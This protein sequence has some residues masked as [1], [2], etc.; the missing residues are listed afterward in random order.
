MK[1]NTTKLF[2]VLTTVCVLLT[3]FGA[4][5]ENQGWDCK[6][7]LESIAA[8]DEHLKALLQGIEE[9][10]RSER[11]FTKKSA[12]DQFNRGMEKERTSNGPESMLDPKLQTK[13]WSE[14]PDESQ[15]TAKV[16]VTCG[17]KLTLLGA[18]ADKLP[19]YQKMYSESDGTEPIEFLTENFGGSL[20]IMI[21]SAEQE[22]NRSERSEID[23][24]TLQ[25]GGMWLFSLGWPFCCAYQN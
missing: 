11:Q 20:Y 6:S 14:L 25:R 5:A 3:P 2:T 21:A 12:T 4:S 22:R 10:E 18:F 13:W 15:N 9:W 8:S 16:A 1:L 17:A 19:E 7:T 24:T 23:A